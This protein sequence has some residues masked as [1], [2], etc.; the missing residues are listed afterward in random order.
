MRLEE[1]KDIIKKAVLS[2]CHVRTTNPDENFFTLLAWLEG[3]LLGL[4]GE[5]NVWAS[6]Q[7]KDVFQRLRSAFSDP[8]SEVDLVYLHDLCRVAR[9]RMGALITSV[10]GYIHEPHPES[11]E[12]LNA[13]AYHLLWECRVSRENLTDYGNVWTR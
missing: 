5:I 8:N 6:D 1:G 11:E 13:L 9:I 10:E 12:N 7:D 2:W 3:S 4:L